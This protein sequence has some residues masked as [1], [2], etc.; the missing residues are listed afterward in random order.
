MTAVGA[1]RLRDVRLADAAV[2]GGK[3]AN[4]GELIANG[5]RVP[6]GVVLGLDAATLPDAERSRL[7]T[8]A[9]SALG[10]DRFAVRSSGATEDGL[11]RSFAGLFETVLDVPPGGLMAASARVLASVRDHRVETYSGGSNDGMAV[12][13][14]RMV[15][16]VAA[17]V[18]MTADPVTGDRSTCVVTAVRGLAAALVSGEVP[19]DEW[20][21]REG[22]ATLARRLE[23]AIDADVA[24][25]VAAEA[26]R[27]AGL[28][29]VPQDI[30]WAL[31]RDGTLWIVQ[32]RP[33]TAVPPEVKWDPP[34][35]GAFTRSYRFGEWLSEPVT[36]LFESW[37][38]TTME[39]R[40]HA[41]LEA[42]LGQRMP[43]PYHVLVNGWY[44]YSLNW[45]TPGAF[46]RNAPRMLVRAV[47]SPRALAGIMPAT[48]RHAFPAVERQWREDVQP[49]YRAAVTK[50]QEQVERAAIAELPAMVDELAGLAG[51]YFLSIAALTGAAY[52]T[53]LN[54]AAFHR[55]HLQDALGWSHLPLVSGFEATIDPD[56]PAIVSL[57]WWFEPRRLGAEAA[58]PE[59]KHAA[60]VEERRAA[61]AKARAALRATPGR[62]RSYE[63]LLADAQHLL[64]IRDEQ[65]RE[66]TLAW[67]VMRRAVL[68][69]GTAL[70]TGGWVDEPDD[71]FFLTRAELLAAI[72]GGARVARIDVRERRRLREEQV[73]L[74]PPLVVGPLPRMVERMWAGFAA[75]VGAVG[76]ER[77]LVS[78]APASAGRATGVARV[79]RG[80]AEFETL[81][82]GEILVAPM[83][84]PAWTPL[85]ARA[86]GLVTDVGSAASHASLVAREYGIP[87]VVGTGDATARLRT[88]MRVT[89]DGSTGTVE[90]A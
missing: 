40:L 11:D 19:G 71:A 18:A 55:K 50:A 52:K 70:S 48:V 26:S 56:A 1:R 41:G 68:R 84:A 9:A 64:A 32:A 85:F 21:I 15:D 49:R 8:A 54:L 46:L 53:E 72:G 36:P 31:D 30:E 59:G 28:R 65:T 23:G 35:R 51:E 37:L 5:V 87:A 33:M 80:P 89:V 3:A 38:L 83:T 45:A 34:V 16:A 81:Q 47:R 12:I 74:V 86:A 42:V 82:P 7:L 67:P 73:R 13:V 14:Q 61:E 4:L 77:A 66:L 25:A 57:D 6:D 17:G 69:I 79:V 43:R 60:V 88:G 20:R 63:R 2:V 76:S 10:A 90:A 29:G 39:E 27:I 78:G 62:L 75:Q 44:F 58:A 22:R 24:L